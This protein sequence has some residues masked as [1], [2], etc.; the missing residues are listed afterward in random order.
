MCWKIAGVFHARVSITA[1]HV[2]RQDARE[3]V[4]ETAAGDVREAF[5]H[6]RGQAREQRLVVAMHAQQFV[7]ERLR[8]AG[9]LRLQA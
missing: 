3:I 1:S 2:L 8:H 5:H 9:E 7:A 6:A 4:H